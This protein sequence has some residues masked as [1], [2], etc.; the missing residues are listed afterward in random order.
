M[1]KWGQD[2]TGNPIVNA[3]DVLTRGRNSFAWHELMLSEAEQQSPTRAD[4]LKVLR[5]FVTYE[6]G[7]LRN[8][9]TSHKQL[10]VQV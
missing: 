4:F 3:L 9:Q 1:K 5:A 8:V 6:E 2:L 7:H 10:F